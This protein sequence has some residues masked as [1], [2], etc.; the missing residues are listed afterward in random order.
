MELN[1][2]EVPLPSQFG[3]CNEKTPITATPFEK[4]Q[5]DVS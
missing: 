4:V 2:K 5:L 1:P 3:F